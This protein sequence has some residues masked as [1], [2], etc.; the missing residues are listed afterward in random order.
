VTNSLSSYC[1][2]AGSLQSGQA[3]T[4]SVIDITDPSHPGDTKALKLRVP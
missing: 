1:A 3:P 4:F 2:A